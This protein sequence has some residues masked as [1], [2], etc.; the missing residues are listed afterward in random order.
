[1]SRRWQ[2]TAKEREQ[3]S[4]MVAL[5]IPQTAVCAIMGVTDK[6]LNRACR[7]EIT[8]GRAKA[9]ITIG[10][11]LFQVAKRGNVAAMIFWLKTR[12]GWRETITIEQSKPVAEMSDAELNRVLIANGLEPIDLTMGETSVV[13]FPWRSRR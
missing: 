8:T 6:T 1:M 7:Y 12:A 3:V 9:N 10:E 13:P 2:P 5:G 11:K 4:T